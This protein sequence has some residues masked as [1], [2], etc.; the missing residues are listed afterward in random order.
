MKNNYTYKTL[1]LGAL[2]LVS[3]FAFAETEK[4][5]QIFRNG[6]IIQQY[7]VSDIDYIEVNDV[8]VGSEF[9][10]NVVSTGKSKSGSFKTAFLFKDTWDDGYVFNLSASR[11]NHFNEL[12]GNMAIE[13]YVGA[14]ELYNGQEF[15]VADTEYPFSFKFEYVNGGDL[16]AIVIDNEHRTGAEGTIAV[17]PNGRGTF[18][19]VFDVTMDSGDATVK[20]Y[21]A[22]EYNERN[23]IYN[24]ADGVLG[25]VKGATLDISSNPCVVYFTTGDGEAGP[26]NYDV[27]GEVPAS[28]WQFGKYMSFSGQDSSVEWINGVIYST[29][30]KPQT[31][32]FGGNWRVM[33]PTYTPSGHTV[34]ECSSTLFGNPSCFLY[35]YGEI[36]IIE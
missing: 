29:E 1:A 22:G 27:K 32:Y 23:T 11:L 25:I 36:K 18:D 13:L 8:L 33:E 9:D 12:G 35:Y 19:V 14:K 17:I 24:T 34:A 30:T 3:L 16:S 2:S 7:A 4:A 31:G 20:G 26:D 28:E 15:N 21:Y 6:E 10:Y 5:I